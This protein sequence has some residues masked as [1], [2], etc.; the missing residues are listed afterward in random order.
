M[1][2]AVERTARIL[3]GTGVVSMRY[4]NPLMVPN[5]IVQL[6]HMTMGRVIF[7]ML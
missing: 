1:I 6:D 2:A 4:H 7:G 5:R 3:L